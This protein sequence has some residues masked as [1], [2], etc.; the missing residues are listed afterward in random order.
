MIST[1]L[2]VATQ[3]DQ[4]AEVDHAR[5]ADHVRA[6]P[7]P[8]PG[9]P[10]R[11]LGHDEHLDD[12][13]AAGHPADDA[14]ARGAR[15][16]GQGQ[17]QEAQPLHGR[18]DGVAGRGHEAARGE[19]RQEGRRHAARGQAGLGAAGAKKPAPAPR[20]RRPAR[21]SSARQ[22]AG[23][24]P[25]QPAS[26]KPKGGARPAGQGR[27]RPASSPGKTAAG[28]QAGRRRARPGRRRRNDHERGRSGETSDA[29]WAAHAVPARPGSRIDGRAGRPPADRRRRR[30]DRVRHHRRRRHH[31]GGQ[32][33]GARAA[34]QDRALHQPRRRRV[35]SSSR[36][37][38][39]AASSAAARARR[40]VEARLCPAGSASKPTCPPAPRRCASSSRP[41]STSWASRRRWAPARRRVVRA[42]ISGDDLG[43]LI[44][45]H[46]ATIDALQYI[47]AIVVN[48]DR[49]ERRQVD[50]RRG[51]VPGPP[52]DGAHVARRPHRAE[53]RA[54]VGEHHPQADDAR[55]SARS[56]H[57]HLKDHPRVETVVGGQGAVPRRRRLAR[58]T[59][60]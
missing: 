14:Q 34:A 12:R 26:A 42:E 7:L 60:V 21:P 15:A 1:E 33:H 58:Q 36:R 3:S 8:V 22:V 27:G 45:R 17:A 9:R 52:R 19:D 37:A 47:A 13:P 40:S 50:R 53:G 46:G 49:R 31:R 20:S 2:M 59:A 4:H 35:S 25:G 11:V 41:P 57:L 39:R 24:K 10:V 56:M 48:G 44:G 30:R 18:H 51:G 32:A 16:A 29:A 54:G 43:L 23:G 6:L 55:P 38:A 28:R 5:D